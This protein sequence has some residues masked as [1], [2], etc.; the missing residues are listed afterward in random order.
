VGGASGRG[1][2]TP[3]FSTLSR[4]Y[5]RLDGLMGGV[6]QVAER[7]ECSEYPMHVAD[8][9]TPFLPMR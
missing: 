5:D 1:S 4:V 6:I 7:A 2:I 9:G 3:Q 8:T